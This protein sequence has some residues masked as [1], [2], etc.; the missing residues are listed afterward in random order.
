MYSNK[1]FTAD[2]IIERIFFCAKEQQEISGKQVNAAKYYVQYIDYRGNVHEATDRHLCPS[3]GH[4]L[5]MGTQDSQITV[6]LRQ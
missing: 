6:L 4:P 3:C 1:P 5:D 2:Q